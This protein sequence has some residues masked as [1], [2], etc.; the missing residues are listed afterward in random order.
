MCVSRK[1]KSEDCA[2][3]TAD[4][5]L[6]FHIDGN[7]LLLWIFRS[8]T[9]FSMS[10]HPPPLTAFVENRTRPPKFIIIDHRMI[11]SILIPNKSNDSRLRVVSAPY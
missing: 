9:P 11:S 7:Y 4:M 8:H 6:T 5:Q 2:G 3:Y 10:H 1:V